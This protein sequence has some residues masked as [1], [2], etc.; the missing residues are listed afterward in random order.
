MSRAA[1]ETEPPEYRLP[2]GAIAYGFADVPQMKTVIEDISPGL[3]HDKNAARF[4]DKSDYAVVGVYQDISDGAQPGSQSYF[5]IT[6]GTYPA[7]SYNFALGFSSNWKKVSIDGKKWWRQG[8]VALL[9]EK[10]EAR[11]QIGQIGRTPDQTMNPASGGELGAFFA[12]ARREAEKDKTPLAFA[13]YV[14]SSET[15]SLIRRVGIPFDISLQNIT[16]TSFADPRAET[17][18][19]STLSLTARSP[20]EAKALAAILSLARVTIGRRGQPNAA[21]AFITELLFANPPAFDGSTVIIS[22]TFPL[23]ALI[24]IIKRQ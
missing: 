4:V 3:L 7:Y 11:I 8:T 12:D 21:N 18:Y 5:L 16:L 6:R 9:I 13:Y 2:P 10:N 17:S 19:Q 1:K 20:S 15:A 24:R 14:P 22:G 23:D